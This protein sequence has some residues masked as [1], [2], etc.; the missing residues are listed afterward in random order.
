[1]GYNIEVFSAFAKFHSKPGRWEA[2][3]DGDKWQKQIGRD[4]MKMENRPQ[5]KD[6]EHYAQVVK[7]YRGHIFRTNID[8]VRYPD[9]KLPQRTEE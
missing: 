7:I 4:L 1:M 6:S 2:R 9:R 8:G 3:I 5:Q